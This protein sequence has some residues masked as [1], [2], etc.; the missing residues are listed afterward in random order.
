MCGIILFDCHPDL[1]LSV[2]WGLDAILA[3]RYANPPPA[4]LGF[5]MTPSFPVSNLSIYITHF[6]CTSDLTGKRFYNFTNLSSEY[7]MILFR[8]I[9]SFYLMWSFIYRVFFIGSGLW[10]SC[11]YFSFDV[12]H[13]YLIFFGRWYVIEWGIDHNCII[14]LCWEISRYV[15]NAFFDKLNFSG[16]LMKFSIS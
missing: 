6:M 3:A 10:V 9:S 15:K 4:W 14:T 5:K 13:W 7:H 11:L 12:V 2:K 1:R 8:T 16:F